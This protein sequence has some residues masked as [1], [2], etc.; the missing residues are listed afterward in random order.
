MAW[1]LGVLLAL[2]AGGAKP[3]ETDE[4]LRNKIQSHIDTIVDEGAALV[5]DVA[6]S[7]RGNES[8]QEAGKF[9][10]DVIDV[11]EETAEDLEGVLDDARARVEERFG[12]DGSAEG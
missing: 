7:L 11:T 10:Q 3:K 4:E 12:A 8:L 2:G 6:E 9:I 5:D 1:I